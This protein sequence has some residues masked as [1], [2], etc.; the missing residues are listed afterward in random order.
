MIMFL[1]A[2][3]L[4]I[5]GLVAAEYQ[6][7]RL[8]EYTQNAGLTAEAGIEQSVEELNSQSS[9]GGYSTPQTY[10]NNTTEG[11]G[12]FTTTITENANGK[13]KTITS[14]GE[15]Y[16]NDSA[17][18]P[19]VTRG[20]QVT[21]VGTGSTGYSVLTGPGGLI[22]SGSANITNSSVYVSG[23]II[24]NGSSRIGTYNQPV[25]VNVANNACP[26]GPSP[27][28][29][30]PQVCTNGSQPI[31]LSS[32]TAIYGSVCAT[33]QTSTGPNSNIQGG[34]GGAGLE[35]G[36]TAPVNLPTVYNRPQQISQVTTTA[37]GGDSVYA[38][39]GS[40][41]TFTW[42]GNLELTG[43][44]NIGDNCNIT[45]DGNVWI[46]GNLT[47]GG[48][49]TLTVENGLTTPPVIMVDGT[50][51]VDG[52]ASMITNNSGVGIEYIS[53]DSANSC[54]TSTTDYCS[55]LTGNDLYNSQ[56]MQTIDVTG[57]VNLP[58]MIFDSQWSEVTIDGSGNVGAATGQTVNLDGGGSVIF[59][60]ELASNTTT[61]SITS[62]EPYYPSR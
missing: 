9:F 60:T 55:T 38:C 12:V 41:Q 47:I 58:G 34:N 11:K 16:V 4:A 14:V 17:T 30:Y 61:W 28:S 33:G 1:T 20:V 52:S 27:G 7:S 62:Y 50:I 19:Y 42:P 5:M 2:V 10:F 3:G 57:R 40:N 45:V 22:L 24:M 37:S 21:V 13:S 49:A 23:T 56:T 26:N 36:C 29:T 35:T 32:S 39:G 54:T 51:T 48:S 31:T 18:T 6:Q 44:V 8:E 15:V 46:T 53:F 59:G 25:T 43:N